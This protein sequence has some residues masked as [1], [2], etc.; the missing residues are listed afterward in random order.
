MR[1]S[2]LIRKI[3]DK[4]VSDNSKI[5]PNCKEIGLDL[6][7]SELA[8]V[9]MILALGFVTSIAFVMYE[10]ISRM[11]KRQKVPN[12]HLIKSDTLHIQSFFQSL[13]ELEDTVNLIGDQ[14]KRHLLDRR[15]KQLQHLSENLSRKWSFMNLC[16]FVSMVNKLCPLIMC[17]IYYLIHTYILIHSAK[18]Q[19]VIII[20]TYML[21]V[22]SSISRISHYKTRQNKTKFQVKNK[23]LFRW[24]VR[25]AEWIIDDSCPVHSY[26]RIR[27]P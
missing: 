10:K 6:G 3:I 13:Q 27:C 25:L 15:L 11:F 18:P 17:I 2:G 12:P 24:P 1:E 23:V 7:Y 26:F 8:G 20:F 19:P 22:H 4:W 5:T 14:S 16:N 9:F 21:L